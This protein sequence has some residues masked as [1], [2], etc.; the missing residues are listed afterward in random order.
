MTQVLRHQE[1]EFH[2][3]CIS[4][5]VENVLLSTITMHTCQSSHIF[6]GGPSGPEVLYM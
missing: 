5:L 1:I 4:F 6:N 3:A 2:C